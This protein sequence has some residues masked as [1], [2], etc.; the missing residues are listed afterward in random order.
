MKLNCPFCETP[1]CPRFLMMEE[2]R[3]N[4]PRGMGGGLWV[5]GEPYREAHAECLRRRHAKDEPQAETK[6]P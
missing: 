2:K 6:E 5:H 4:P 3:K 1:D